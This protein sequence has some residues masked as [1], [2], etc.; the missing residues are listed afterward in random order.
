[1]TDESQR[2]AETRSIRQYAESVTPKEKAFL[3]WVCRNGDDKLST[4]V[5]S[6]VCFVGADHRLVLDG[7]VELHQEI[8]TRFLGAMELVWYRYKLTAAGHRVLTWLSSKAWGDAISK[9]RRETK[10]IADAH[11][12][13]RKTKPAKPRRET[14]DEPEIAARK[15]Q[16]GA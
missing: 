9:I 6:E 15:R 14:R 12:R 5:P 3:H 13:G 1:M 2:D 11:F 4:R 8:T 10:H 16:K 7:M